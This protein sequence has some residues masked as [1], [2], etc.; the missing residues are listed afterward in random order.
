MALITR[1]CIRQSGANFPTAWKSDRT[2]SV[3]SPISKLDCLPVN[4]SV[5]GCVQLYR[6]DFKKPVIWTYT[7]TA[8]KYS[9]NDTPP[10]QQQATGAFQCIDSPV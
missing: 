9:E 5:R 6:Y 2:T 7:V 3:K 10:A 4:P 1:V 8:Q